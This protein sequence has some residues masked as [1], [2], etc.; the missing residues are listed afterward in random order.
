[1][2]EALGSCH[3]DVMAAAYCI[4]SAYKDAL[5]IYCYGSYQVSKSP[6]LN[7]SYRDIHVCKHEHPKLRVVEPK[8]R[9]IL[10]PRASGPGSSTSSTRRCMLCPISTS[11]RTQECANK[12]TTTCSTSQ[13]AKLAAMTT[14]A[15]PTHRHSPLAQPPPA[16]RTRPTPTTP[17]Q[18]RQ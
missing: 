7:I 3:G 9:G 15:S 12:L 14:S 17:S 16:T 11:F 1:M 8:A 5:R 18:A 4:V 10:P 13:D 6:G 2:Q